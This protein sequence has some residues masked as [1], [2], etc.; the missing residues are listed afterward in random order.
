M[1]SLLRGSAPS[2][3]RAPTSRQ[4]SANPANTF[5]AGTLRSSTPRKPNFILQASDI[6]P[7]GTPQVGTVDI[8][9]SGNL[10]GAFTLWRTAPVDSDIANPLS[11]KLNITVVD[12]GD[13]SSGAPT[14]AAGD[15]VD[16]Y[17]GTLADDGRDRSPVASL[18]TYAAG[19]KHRYQFSVTARRLGRQRVPGRQLVGRVRLRRGP[20]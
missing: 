7:A 9:N 13:F 11:G 6:K 12:C 3:A 16:K 10:A 1:A 17:S 18:G 5:A 14:C 8:E 4:S 19:E 2:S 20:A 15:D